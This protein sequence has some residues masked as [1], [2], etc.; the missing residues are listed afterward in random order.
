MATT[1]RTVHIR[2]D[3]SAWL[4]KRRLK[5]GLAAWKQVQDMIDKEMKKE[6]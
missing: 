2:D 4:Q 5:T 1:K 6:K 3:Q